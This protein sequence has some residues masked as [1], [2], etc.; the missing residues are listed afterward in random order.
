M[1][2]EPHIRSITGLSRAKVY[3]LLNREGCPVVRFGRAIR[4]PRDAFLKY[5]DQLA[6]VEE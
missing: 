6:G 2:K 5:L 1:L 4:V 3:E